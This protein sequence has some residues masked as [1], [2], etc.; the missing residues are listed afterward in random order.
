MPGSESVGELFYAWVPRPFITVQ[1]NL[2]F[3]RH[4]GGVSTNESVVVVGLR[5]SVDF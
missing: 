5:C 4:P 2:Q 1:P 3:V